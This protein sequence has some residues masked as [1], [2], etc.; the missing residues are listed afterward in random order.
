MTYEVSRTASSVRYPVRIKDDANQPVLG[1]AH[2]SAGLEIGYLTEGA[3][4]WTELSLVAASP[5]VYTENGFVA[6]AG[7]DGWYEIG[8]P[9]AAIKPDTTTLVRVKTAA[10]G[11]RYGD[12]AA[13]DEKG[14]AVIEEPTESGDLLENA[15][16]PR[17]ATIDGQSVTNRA[18]DE[19]IAADRY[20]N[21]KKA[22]APGFGIALVRMRPGSAVNE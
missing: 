13:T 11:Y 19:L 15:F 12:I 2:D 4:S 14:A 20:Q 9:D 8:L 1:L 21:A 18:V 7:G 16:E 17:A 10:F 22:K 6:M 5:G 3:A